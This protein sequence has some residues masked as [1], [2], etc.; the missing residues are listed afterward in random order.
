MLTMATPC[1][2]TAELLDAE[3]VIGPLA[4]V[5]ILHARQ[6]EPLVPPGIVRRHQRE[7]QEILGPAKLHA[8]NQVGA[9]HRSDQVVEEK[10]LLQVG[11]VPGAGSDRYVEVM[12]DEVDHVL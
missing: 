7:A 2:A 5:G 10:M 9:A 4:Q 11:P 12:G 3:G 6:R 8:A 1:P